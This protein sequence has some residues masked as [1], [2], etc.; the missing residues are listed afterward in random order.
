MP[1]LANPTKPVTDPEPDDEVHTL[2]LAILAEAKLINLQL[3]LITKLELT[4]AELEV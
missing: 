4:T 2:L 1:G 3:S